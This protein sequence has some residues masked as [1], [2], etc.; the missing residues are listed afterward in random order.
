MLHKIPTQHVTRKRESPS[1]GFELGTSRGS[2]PS[3][4]MIV[5]RSA[6]E[7]FGAWPTLQSIYRN[8]NILL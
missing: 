7:K 4:V 5:C 2:A 3:N 6:G 1:A 8:P